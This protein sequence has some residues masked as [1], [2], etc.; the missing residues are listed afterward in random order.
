MLTIIQVPHKPGCREVIRNCSRDPARDLITYL[1][2]V[3]CCLGVSSSRLPGL[4]H[5]GLT[6]NWLQHMHFNAAQKPPFDSI[7]LSAI[8]EPATK[9]HTPPLGTD[10]EYHQPG[11]GAPSCRSALHVPDHSSTYLGISENISTVTSSSMR[12]RRSQ[13]VPSMLVLFSRAS[14]PPKSYLMSRP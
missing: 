10:N 5:R 8:H 1:F 9:S 13:M 4:A 12:F 11:C 3:W 2:T 7:T 14:S 6:C